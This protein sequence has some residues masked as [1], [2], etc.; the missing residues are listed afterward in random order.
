MPLYALLFLEG[1]EADTDELRVAPDEAVLRGAEEDVR[2][3]P[4]ERGADAIEA[5]ETDERVVRLP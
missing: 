5:D 4:V 2:M 3:V 1:T